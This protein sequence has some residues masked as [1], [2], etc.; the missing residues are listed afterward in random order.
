MWRMQRVSPVLWAD[1]SSSDRQGIGSGQNAR[2]RAGRNPWNLTAD[3]SWPPRRQRSE[4]RSSLRLA[5][6]PHRLEHVRRAPS[7]HC[8]PTRACSRVSKRGGFAPAVQTSSSGTGE[9]AR[10]SYCSMATRPHTHPGTR[11]PAAWQDDFTLWRLTFAATVT[12]S[13]PPRV[14][15]TTSTTRSGPWPRIRSR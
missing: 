13:V 9:T 7:R 15:P 14:A 4:L 12:A 1:I 3:S 6:P 8:R 11:L 5:R 10:L 2:R